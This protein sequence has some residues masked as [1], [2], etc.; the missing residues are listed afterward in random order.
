MPNRDDRSS[1]VRQSQCTAGGPE[2][3]RIWLKKKSRVRRESPS[4]RLKVL[5]AGKLPQIFQGHLEFVRQ[6]CEHGQR[7]T[8]ERVR[9]GELA[10]MQRQALNQ[11]LFLRAAFVT[12][13]E[14]GES[15]TDL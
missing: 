11:R 1:A 2:I 10:G 6:G 7:F 5:A 13:L 9:E 4:L 14:I 15:K 8:R 3:L 12:A